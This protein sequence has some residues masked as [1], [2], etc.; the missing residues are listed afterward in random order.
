MM[1]V[2]A[3]LFLLGMAANSENA[4]SGCSTGECGEDSA[5]L[6]VRDIR[7]RRSLLNMRRKAS[8]SQ[9]C[10]NYE[11]GVCDELPNPGNDA[12]KCK[13]GKQY[14]DLCKETYSG[15]NNN[16]DCKKLKKEQENSCKDDVKKGVTWGATECMN[17]LRRNYDCPISCNELF[18]TYQPLQQPPVVESPVTI[19]AET[20]QLC[21]PDGNDPYKVW[22][23]RAYRLPG[24]KASIAGPTIVTRPGDELMITVQNNLY[25]P[26]PECDDE[27]VITQNLEG[28]EAINDT[29][30]GC[31][32]PAVPKTNVVPYCH[33]NTTNLHTHGLHVT[34]KPP[35]D[36]IFV[37]IPPQTENTTIVNLP[38]NHGA[39][40][41]WYHPH[42]HHSTASQAGG[43]MAGAL[44]VSD[45]KGTLP[46]TIRDMEQIVV[47]IQ[48]IDLRN[49][50]F[51]DLTQPNA[52]EVFGLGN[53][54]E[55]EFRAAGNLWSVGG[56]VVSENK[57]YLFTNGQYKPEL[58]MKENKWVR[59]QMV[60]G[61]VAYNVAITDRPW[62]DED[63]DNGFQC[64]FQLLAKDGV[65][66]SP[67]LRIVKNLYI[68]PGA[69]AEVVTRCWCEQA[70]KCV[71][72][73]VSQ[74]CL[75]APEDP[76]GPETVTG[77]NDTGV[78]QRNLCGPFGNIIGQFTQNQEILR[79]NV[80]RSDE[81]PET[82]RKFEV[83]RPCYLADTFNGA[84][85]DSTVIL[86]PQSSF[87]VSPQFNQVF[88]TTPE[89]R[90]DD[91]ASGNLTGGIFED[92]SLPIKFLDIGTLQ[93]IWVDG[94]CNVS[95]PG[96]QQPCCNVP[97]G[98]DTV[99]IVQI[100]FR[101]PPQTSGP[102]LFPKMEGTVGGITPHTFHLHISP[103]QVTELKCPNGT[104]ITE[105]GTG[106][107]EYGSY[108]EWYDNYFQVGDWQDNFMYAGGAF[109]GRFQA[110]SFTGRWIFH[111]HVLDHED[112]G[113]MAYFQVTGEEGTKYPA[114]QLLDP[115]CYEGLEVPKFT[116]VD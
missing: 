114:Q 40:V 35:G 96:G 30:D 81:A 49:E 76:G 27:K 22:F 80:K 63:K 47:L 44:V 50:T 48:M 104:W 60:Y 110:S 26:S 29:C 62:D 9:F 73:L 38:D 6:V 55:L 7:D 4:T 28:L 71:G 42:R 101:Y 107:T 24:G 21:S 1:H 105:P 11:T 37:H 98:G 66:L 74:P 61:A 113:M 109:K 57:L 91:Y 51:R 3:L 56:E 115:T 65:Y 97:P 53:N 25:N 84:V 20:T 93:E 87:P 41:M 88:I 68:A 86:L 45:E 72:S 78:P 12:K 15:K 99:E 90:L 10:N 58:T 108:G 64:E 83:S 5:L 39:G 112:S 31:I 43:G 17:T 54:P 67:A 59:L 111:C 75:E 13:F 14:K 95:C 16:K 85:N 103:Y 100:P 79:I 23:T 32:D 82:L 8:G 106:C 70:G 19:I 102:V 46:K 18:P 92:E 52:T 89:R 33:I 116:Y 34:P 77:M 36:S 94:G 2:V 69:R